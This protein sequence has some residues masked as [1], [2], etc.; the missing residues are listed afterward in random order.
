[1]PRKWTNS[2]NTE[3]SHNHRAMHS[4]RK[5]HGHSAKVRAAKYENAQERNNKH[6]QRINAA[7]KYAKLVEEFNAAE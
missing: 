2:G 1:M 6:R 3:T 5:G 4:A 7:K